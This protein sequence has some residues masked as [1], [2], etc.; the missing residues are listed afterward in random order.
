MAEVKN[1]VVTV[2]GL[3]AV[4]DYNES[5]YLKRTNALTTIGITA[6]STEL[7][8]CDGVTSNIQTQLNNKAA[9]SHTHTLAN[10]S[11][12]AIITAGLATTSTTISTSGDSV[13]YVDIPLTLST[14]VGSSL[15]VSD[16]SIVIGS[17]ISK[18]KISAQALVGTPNDLTVVKSVAIRKNAATDPDGYL[19]RTQIRFAQ[20]SRPESVSIPTLVVGVTEGDI[21]SL[22]YCGAINDVV[23][24][25][26]KICTYM[27][28]E[29]VA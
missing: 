19:A 18:V 20:A 22:S 9:S 11:D 23:Y 16:G 21:I 24:G 13:G 14:S 4:H 2:E 29:K 1:K 28:I 3:D 15:T 8:Y 7:N 12:R 26:N 17:G 10:L 27:T 6:T 5:T 25:Y